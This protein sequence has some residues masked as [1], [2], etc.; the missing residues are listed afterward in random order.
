MTKYIFILLLFTGCAP[1]RY[2]VAIDPNAT[3]TVQ[4]RELTMVDR[5]RDLYEQSRK[6]ADRR[7]W[8]QT[9]PVWASAIIMGV[10][11]L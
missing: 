1:T 7:A 10:V 3:I 11:L 4:P 8:I 2:P 6:D 5:N 9:L